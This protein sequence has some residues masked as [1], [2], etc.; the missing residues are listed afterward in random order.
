VTALCLTAVAALAWPD[1]V[2]V[3]ELEFDEAQWAYA[4]DHPAED[5]FVP[6][7]LAVAGEEMEAEFRIRGQ[8][9]R[10]YAKKSIKVRLLGGQRLW[11]FDELNLNAQYRDRTR[12]R[13]NLSYIFHRRAGNIVPD[14]HLVELVFNGQTQ[15][16]YTFVED[17]DGDF[18]QRHPLADE[19]VIYKCW[20]DGSS[21]DRPWEL[22][23]YQK[24]T[25]EEEPF[26]DLELLI[27][28]LAFAP[29]SDFASGLG[30][31]VALTE[32]RDFV[33]ANVLVGNGSCYYHNYLMVLDRPGG[34][35]H[36]HPVVWDMDRTWGRSYGPDFPY[37]WSDNQLNRPNP[38]VWRSWVDDGLHARM[39]ARLWELV[40]LLHA[41]E[42]G[43]TIDSLAALAEPLVE[44]DPFRE[45]SM[46]EFEEELDIVRSW[47]ELREGFLQ[48]QLADWPAPFRVY[49][50]V[51]EGGQCL[52]RWSSA[53]PGCSY[54][55]EVS[56]DS[57]FEDP[58]AMVA[59]WTTQ[60]TAVT[61]GEQLAP[62]GAFWAV[63]ADNGLF[64][65]LSV[66][67]IQPLDPFWEEPTHRG[68]LVI[69]E[70]NYSSP[71]DAPSGDWIE[72][73]NPGPDTVWTGGWTIR[74]G[75]ADHLHTMDNCPVPPGEAV[76]V[77]R[78][79]AAFAGQH[80]GC[81]TDGD[82]MD[83]GL[84]SDGER[85][86]LYDLGG[87]MSDFVRYDSKSP[88]PEGPDGGGPTLSLL[89]PALD[90][91]LAGSWFAGPYRG[92]PGLPNDSVPCWERGAQI[93][94][95]GVRPNPARETASVE[96]QLLYSGMVELDLYD[97]SGRL[98]LRG[99]VT[100][101]PRGSSVLELDLQGLEA[102]VYWAVVR[103][104]GLSRSAGL[105]VLP[106]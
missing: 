11:G 58:G 43:G 57:S 46:E 1:S 76:V 3:L 44:A 24:K 96:V 55:V 47:P 100:E 68:Q 98:R 69:N 53:G 49:R 89:D 73:C 18:L 83:F 52:L 31:R 5:I 91:S 70:I 60:D 62:H 79:S 19:G 38:L 86:R 72:L 2:A 85:L 84:S 21:L 40:P 65:K 87:G 6:A 92:T 94:L 102:G 27:N 23:V 30:E 26:D 25:H 105:V 16:A 45:Y 36:W 88:W 93:V 12:I 106:R 103:H 33:V 64:S 54:T 41:M 56:A 48:E 59:S 71:P 9:S 77:Y 82:G 61:V 17:V 80:P 32:L 104:R 99:G 78:D 75:G 14:A 13:E 29:D 42:T 37:Y 28:W 34:I 8:S 81:P 51:R 67:R 20:L 95:R 39:E 22:D 7:V 66:N 10:Y 74:D 101:L 15:G 50:P 35:G 4:C 63:T 97:L 90:N